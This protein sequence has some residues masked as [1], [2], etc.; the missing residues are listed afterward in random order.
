VPLV[1]VLLYVSEYTGYANLFR[2]K[3]SV[4]YRNIDK[5]VRAVFYKIAILC[6]VTFEW[7][8]LLGLECSY[9]EMID[10][11]LNARYE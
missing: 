3:V 10:E 11:S 6:S 4:N 8:V 7:L 5:I 2:K 1:G 9:T